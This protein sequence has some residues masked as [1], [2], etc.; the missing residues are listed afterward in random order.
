M[1]TDKVVLSSSRLCSRNR[2]L[3]SPGKNNK[4]KL[5]VKIPLGSRKSHVEKIQE[6]RTTV[7]S[8][9]VKNKMH[10]YPRQLTFRN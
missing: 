6:I 2:L 8:K 1:K 7:E 10:S 5:N 3:D 9:Y 4:L